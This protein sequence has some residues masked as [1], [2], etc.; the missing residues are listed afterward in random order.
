MLGRREF[1][2]GD[3]DEADEGTRPKFA[4]A[5]GESLPSMIGSSAWWSI[6]QA[7]RISRG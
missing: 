6:Q 5:Q 4:I 7:R 3:D 2:V 1:A